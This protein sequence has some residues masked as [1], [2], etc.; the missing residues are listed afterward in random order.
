MGIY[1]FAWGNWALAMLFGYRSLVARK[2]V[3][4]L[5][6]SASLRPVLILPRKVAMTCPHC[7][8]YVEE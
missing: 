2:E 5:R 3:N 4:R 7:G 8:A 6:S 1:I